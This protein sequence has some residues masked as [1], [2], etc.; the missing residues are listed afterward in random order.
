[1]RGRLKACRAFFL[2]GYS[3]DLKKNDADHPGL[4]DQSNLFADFFKDFQHAVELQSVWVA[5]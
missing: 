1:M 5:M 2:F 3:R 4:A